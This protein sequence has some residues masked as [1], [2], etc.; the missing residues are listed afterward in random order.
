[1]NAGAATAT[2]AS[3]DA[4]RRAP[5]LVSIDALRGLVMFTMIFVNDLAGVSP[6]IVPPW[7]RHFKGRS[8]MTFVDLVF[9]AFLF[10][11]GL[12]IPFALGSR[13]ERG[14]PWWKILRHVAVRTLSLLLIGI[15]MV[16]NEVGARIAGWAPELWPAL[17]LG[18]AIFAFCSISPPGT[19]R[20]EL[21]RTLSLIVRGAGLAGLLILAVVF[22][23]EHGERIITFSPFAIRT[24][25][26]GILG[27]IGWAYLVGAVVYLTFRARAAALLGCAALLL[28]FFPAAQTGLFDHFWLNRYVDLG[29]TLGSQASI[30]VG[31]LLLVSILLPPGRMGLG[32][33]VRFALLFVGGFAAAAWLLGGLYGINKN[34]ATP[35]WCLWSCAITAALWLIFHFLADLGPI[36]PVAKVLAVAG[37]NVILAYLISEML[38]SVLDL[39]GW[40]DWYSGLAEANLA[41]ALTRSALC[42]ALI[43]AATTGLNR[44]GFRLRL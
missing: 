23:G 42:A 10:I 36:H 41:A 5:R 21:W 9:P 29:T 35:S 8:G 40:G 11:V 13:L 44:V 16:N 1:M 32:R 14:E 28:C 30:T 3:T 38:P 4:V 17:M 2:A 39:L 25:W 12:S 37:Q 27:L 24:D 15:L 33:R 43:L 20:K 31:G 19:K 26:Y 7:L 18:C 6:R 22:R 34:D